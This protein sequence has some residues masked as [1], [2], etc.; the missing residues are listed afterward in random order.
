MKSK[1]EEFFISAIALYC[2]NIAWAIPTT[3]TNATM[4]AAIFVVRCLISYYI[5][6][7]IVADIG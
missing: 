4:I 1:N 3:T 7:S 6:T 5:L 2:S